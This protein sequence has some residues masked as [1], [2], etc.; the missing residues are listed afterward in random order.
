MQVKLQSV[1]VA[2][3]VVSS[4]G[5]GDP[6]ENAESMYNAVRRKTHAPDMLAGLRYSVLGEQS[7]LCS[8]ALPE[9]ALSSVTES[10]GCTSLLIMAKRAP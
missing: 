3:F 2:L 5:D 8:T 1:R 10:R 9:A 4:T 7:S 6:P